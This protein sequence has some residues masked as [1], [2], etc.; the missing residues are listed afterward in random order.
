MKRVL[1]KIIPVFLGIIVFFTFTGVSVFTED[2]NFALACLDAISEKN[3]NISSVMWEYVK[4]A[5]HTKNLQKIENTRK[6]LIKVVKR[7]IEDAKKMSKCTED[8][9]LR[10]SYIEHLNMLYF[11]LTEDYAKL[12]DMEAIAEESYD[13]M[14]AYFLAKKRAS[15]KMNADVDVLRKKT[16]DFAKKNNIN[17][18][19]EKSEIAENLEKSAQVMDYYNEIYLIF[20]KSYKQELYLINSVNKENINEIEQNRVALLKYANEGLNKLKSKK[21]FA[22]DRSLKEAC[23]QSWIVIIKK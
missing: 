8:K 21:S 9:S 3:R 4:A 2:A 11:L 17:L 23:E 14:E 19:Y 7:A 22:N 16:E 15:E 12:V 6:Q 1:K 10:D 13:A 20:F 18:I 5:A